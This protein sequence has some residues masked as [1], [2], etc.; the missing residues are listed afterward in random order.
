MCWSFGMA[1]NTT[2]FFDQGLRLKMDGFAE[3]TCPV[4]GLGVGDWRELGQNARAVGGARFANAATEAKL[5]D[6]IV[7]IAIQPIQVRAQDRQ[8]EAKRDGE[9]IPEQH[10][11]AS[12]EKFQDVDEFA[13]HEP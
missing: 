1:R 8:Q 6:G 5:A 11:R 4:L 10:T 13:P 2:Q 9:K 12:L 3:Q 7:F